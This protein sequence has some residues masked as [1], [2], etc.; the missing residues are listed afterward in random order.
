V[1]KTI[2]RTASAVLTAAVVAGVATA[3]VV[4]ASADEVRPVVAAAAT[5]TAAADDALVQAW[6]RVYLGRTAAQA[7]G[8]SGRTY[9]VK[10][11]QSGAKQSD[12][13]WRILHSREYN[14][15][16]IADMYDAYLGRTMDS[17]AKYWVDSTSDRGMA[18]EWVEQNILASDEYARSGSLVKRWYADVLYRSPSAGEVAYWDGRVKAKGRLTALRE[19]W[20]ASEVVDLHLAFNYEALLGRAVDAGGRAYWYPKQVESDVN[21]KTLIGA[22]TEFR[23]RHLAA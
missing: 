18:L 10:Q 3:G 17:G 2:R 23:C 13:L 16:E 15:L 19:L 12:V 9:W 20:Y 14:Q 1:R 7:A 8:D 5:S 22:T 21:V 11:L 4:Q 6:Y